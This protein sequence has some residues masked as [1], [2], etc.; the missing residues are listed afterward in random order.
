VQKQTLATVVSATA[1]G[2]EPEITI[3]T[4][5][6]D[7]AQDEII[8]EG[9]DF[10]SYLRNPVVMYGHGHGTSES[11]PVG[12]TTRL[13]VVPGRGIRA[14]WRWLQGDPFADRVRNAYEQGVIRAASIGFLPG[15]REG[16]GRGGQRFKTWQL[17]EWSLV[18][19]PCNAEA[20]RMLKALCLWPDADRVESR[21]DDEEID[22]ADLR[23][24]MREALPALVRG[25]LRRHRTE[26]FEPIIDVTPEELRGIL[27]AVTRDAVGGIVRDETR[28][29]FLRAVGRVD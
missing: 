23:A 1:R 8:P 5:A 16:N 7:R 25:A 21:G 22:A 18:P 4:I 12:S 28:A 20:V 6:L 27:R 17:L 11:L 13:D 26:P 24:A 14:A 29:A 2:D 3:S 15:E 9:G 10:G 19:V